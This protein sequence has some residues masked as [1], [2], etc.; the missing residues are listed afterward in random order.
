MAAGQAVGA[1]RARRSAKRARFSWRRSSAHGSPRLARAVADV[2]RWPDPRSWGH[3]MTF[4]KNLFAACCAIVVLALSGQTASAAI[5]P[6]HQAGRPGAARRQ[7]RRRGPSDGGADRPRPGRDD[8]RREPP[9]RQRHDRHRA[10]VAR[11]ARRQ[12]APDDGQHLSDRRPD[13][14]GE[15]P[16]GHRLRSDLLP[17]AVA[18][19]VRGQQRVALQVR[20]R[21]C[22]TRRAPSPASCRWRRSAPAPRSRWASTRSPRRPAST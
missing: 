20:S 14:E 3:R 10:G 17:G 1:P 11:G 16:S 5:R 7:H 13:P 9:R 18:G 12:H 4:I 21:T 2:A 22:S 6:H 19:G 15:L 8:R